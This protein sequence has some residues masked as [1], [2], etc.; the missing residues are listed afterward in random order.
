[1]SVPDSIPDITVFCKGVSHGNPGPCATGVVASISGNNILMSLSLPEEGT[2]NW[3]DLMAVSQA[4][5]LCRDTTKSLEVVTDNTYVVSVLSGKKPPMA[6]RELIRRLRERISLQSSFSIRFQPRSLDRRSE[7][8]DTIAKVSLRED[9]SIPFHPEELYLREGYVL[10][11][12]KSSK[13]WSPR[14]SSGTSVEQIVPS[15]NQSY[16][17]NKN[18]R[19]SRRDKT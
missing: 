2:G 11:A 15:S 1:M 18:K 16:S 9:V 5:D 12:N 13:S 8:A 4:L 19:R 7:A 6:N 17:K 3:A 14:R 10:P